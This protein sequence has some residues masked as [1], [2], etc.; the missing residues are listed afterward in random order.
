M[1]ETNTAD[2]LRESVN[3]H[4]PPDLTWSRVLDVLVAS[5]DHHLFVQALMQAVAEGGTGCLFRAPV[6]QRCATLRAQVPELYHGTVLELVTAVMAQRWREWD[7]TIGLLI[8]A[9]TTVFPLPQPG[10]VL[11][12]KHFDPLDYLVGEILHEGLTI[13][14]GKPKKGKS[15]LAL[16]MSLSMAVGRL[17]LRHFP[18]KQQRV[19]Y[20]SLEDG[21]RRLQAR[22]RKIQP[23]LTHPGGLDFLYSF[24]KLGAGAL[25]ALTH[26]ATDYGCIIIDVIGRILPDVQTVHKSMSEYQLYTDLFGQLQTFANARHIALLLIDHV[27]KASSDDVYDTI[28]G[29]QGKWGTAD[30]GLVYERKGEEKEALLHVAGREIDEQKFIIDLVDGHLE[31]LGKGELYELASEQN[32]LIRI[33]E[34]ERRPMGIPEIMKAMGIEGE[35]HYMR[36]RQVLARLYAEDRIG[37]TK[38][39]LY[40]V[41]GDDREADVPF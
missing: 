26:Y 1:A 9:P 37:R 6:Q 30:I 32:K 12:A 24:P 23:N 3:G 13:L 11:M 17:A 7:R 29:S 39:G 18:T 15:Y 28:M 8:E 10:P 22:L 34:E 25:E 19:L 27:R 2:E 33:L 36:F 16:D 14:A 40:R 38:R 31:F 5:P 41:Y 35:K 4:L 20:I 21:E